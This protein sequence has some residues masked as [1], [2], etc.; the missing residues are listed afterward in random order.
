MALPSA[1]KRVFSALLSS[2]HSMLSA[3]QI[4]SQFLKLQRG[5]ISEA[6]LSN[7]TTHQKHCSVMLGRTNYAVVLA[8]DKS[9][10]YSL[11]VMTPA[12]E[13]HMWQL[14]S[15]AN[16]RPPT[17][18]EL[19]AIELNMWLQRPRASMPQIKSTQLCQ[20]SKA[21]IVRH[22]TAPPC[23]Y[24]SC[25]ARIP[26]TSVRIYLQPAHHAHTPQPCS[27]AL[28]Q[29]ISCCHLQPTSLTTRG[30]AT[31]AGVPTF[32]T[33]LTNFIPTYSHQQQL[34]GWLLC[35]Q[36]SRPVELPTYSIAT[37][38]STAGAAAASS[39][40]STPTRLPPAADLAGFAAA[41]AAGAPS[42]AVTAAALAVRVGVHC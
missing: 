42:A 9:A 17:A 2:T 29:D 1:I 3:R 18:A 34:N 5:Q 21:A 6:A 16:T 38:A 32:S 22:M 28:L 11:H 14:S 39:T 30:W 25:H 35:T 19:N 26:N 33:Y 37:P 27:P 12:A 4:F 24:C 15:C 31:C 36:T 13:L 10:C 23:Y 20:V 8:Y 41:A 40:C 7:Y